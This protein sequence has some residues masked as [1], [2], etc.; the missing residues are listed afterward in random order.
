MEDKSI[1]HPRK[2]NLVQKLHDQDCMLL[3]VPV[4]HDAE[5]DPLLIL[6]RGEPWFHLSGYVKYQNNRLSMLNH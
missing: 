1:M 6:I 2:T 5:P 3:T 4:V